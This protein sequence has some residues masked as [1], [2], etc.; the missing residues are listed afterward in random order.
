MSTEKLNKKRAGSCSFPQKTIEQFLDE[1]FDNKT[2]NLL[3]IKHW[4]ALKEGPVKVKIPTIAWEEKKFQTP[5]G[6]FEF[7]SHTAEK[8]GLP[9]LPIANQG[10]LPN[11]KYPYWFLSPHPQH[12]LNSQFQNIDWIS[13]IKSEPVV[14]VNPKLAADKNLTSGDLVRIFNNQG[15]IIIKAII[16]KDTP[17]DTLIC[18]QGRHKNSKIN[19]N[20][21]INVKLTDMGKTTTGADGQAFYDVFVNLE[22]I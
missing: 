17:V 2:Y 12:G 1:E 5:S 21:L 6:K 9:A 7:Y 8:A 19:I 22:V 18:Y 15:E 11:Q 3:G 13:S 4:S 14:F 20:K 10:L 16:T